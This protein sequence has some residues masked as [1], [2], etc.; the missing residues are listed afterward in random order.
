MFY[1]ISTTPIFTYQNLLV[2][3]WMEEIVVQRRGREE[4]REK[5][6]GGG[7]D[8]GGG[9]MVLYSQFTLW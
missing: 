5:E 3:G 8:K 6:V 7:G 2:R 4:R 9:Q 1:T